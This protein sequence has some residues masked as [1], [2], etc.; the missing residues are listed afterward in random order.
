[1]DVLVEAY[2]AR[3]FGLVLEAGQD[4]ELVLLVAQPQLV[5]GI[6]LLLHEVI[7][8]GQVLVRDFV[9]KDYSLPELYRRFDLVVV[10]DSL[11]VEQTILK[12]LGA[13]GAAGEGNV[14]AC[15]TWHLRMK[16]LLV[17]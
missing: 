6:V 5:R 8:V 7:R 3:Y 2:L 15:V 1:M 9:S 16:D 11:D 13:F 10:G 14:V 4:F 17:R 12:I